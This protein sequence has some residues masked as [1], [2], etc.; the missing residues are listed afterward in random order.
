MQ[1]RWITAAIGIACSA[2][3]AAGCSPAVLDG[4][5]LSML[6][7]PNRVS[8]LPA[9]DGPSGA[10]DSAPQPTGTGENTDNGE[11]DHL[12]LLALNDLEDFWKQNYSESLQ[13]SFKPI[14][15]LL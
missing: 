7:D 6:Y 14:S 9:V 13:G 1:H 2:L 15:N 12:A 3:F 5:A 10:R 4:R 8:G 11:T